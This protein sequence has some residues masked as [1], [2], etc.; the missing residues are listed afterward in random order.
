MPLRHATPYAIITPIIGSPP[1]DYVIFRHIT[2]RRHDAA[3]ATY[4]AMSLLR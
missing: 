2:L 1:H 4:A 3:F